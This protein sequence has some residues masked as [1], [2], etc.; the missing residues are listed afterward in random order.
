MEGTFTVGCEA[1]LRALRGNSNSL[2]VILSA[3]VADPMFKWNLSPLQARKRQQ[4]RDSADTDNVD[5]QSGR[6][7][8]NEQAERVMARIRE[9]LQGYEDGTSGEQQG[10]EGQVQLVINAARDSKN[11]CK[12]YYGWAPWI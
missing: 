7:G 6:T 11:L 12:M 1:A 5:G 10:I 3:V 8:K 4:D 2:L 9:K